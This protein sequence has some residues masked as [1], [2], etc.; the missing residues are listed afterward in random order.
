MRR[1]VLLPLALLLAI[2]AGCG[3][4][5][6]APREAAQAPALQANFEPEGE[7][8][9]PAPAALPEGRYLLAHL[10]RPALLRLTPGGRTA[11]R[12]ARRTE[13]GSRT[14]LRVVERRDGWLRVLAT[15]R[16]NGKTGW[17]PEASAELRAT[18]FALHVD[19]SARRLALHRD[20]RV[21][22][23][24]TVAIGRPGTPTPTGRF[25][26]TDRLRPSRADSPYGCCAIALTG[27]Q[28]KLVPG[29]PGGDRLAI[30]G[31]PQTETIGKAASLGCMRAHRRDL[32]Y[33]LARLPLGTPVFIR[34]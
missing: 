31:T 33:L 13:F 1:A 4:E 15:Q 21:V 6:A 11:A 30:H 24:M 8:A 18:D 14:V 19:R 2:L 20:G 32:E 3:G 26:V 29:W 34:A 12:L 22:R 9:D 28:T 23:R 7:K 5:P 27:H 17:I 10:K 16:P 25:A